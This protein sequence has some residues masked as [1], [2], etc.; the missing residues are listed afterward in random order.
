MVPPDV[1]RLP[2]ALVLERCG[3]RPEVLGVV[4]ALALVNGALIQVLMASRVF[5]G[6]A[7]EGRIPR[8]LG[9]VSPR[10]RTPL[11]TVVFTVGLMLLATTLLLA[12]ARA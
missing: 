4:A 11:A 8:W 3:G 10:T 5:C 2:R 12:E 7:Q 1:R 9:R 6:L